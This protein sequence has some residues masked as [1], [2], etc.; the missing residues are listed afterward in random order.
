VDAIYHVTRAFINK[1]IEHVEG[2]VNPCRDFDIIRGE[3]RL[4][5]I[6]WMQVQ[7]EKT[8]SESKKSAQRELNSRAVSVA[9]FQLCVF[10]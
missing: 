5:D 4:K 7:L 9:L 3:L 1:D 10:I 2:D 8:R 6:A